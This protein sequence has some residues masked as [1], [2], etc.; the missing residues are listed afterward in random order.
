MTQKPTTEM[1]LKNKVA[2]S[3]AFLASEDASFI[4][5]QELMADGGMAHF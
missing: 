4:T 1:K 3:L 2:K 5:G